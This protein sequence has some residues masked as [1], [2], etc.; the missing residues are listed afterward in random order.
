MFLMSS[1]TPA[2]VMTLSV[3]LLSVACGGD[4]GPIPPSPVPPGGVTTANVYILPGAADLGRNAFG[5][6]PVVIYKGEEMRWRNVDT[7]EHNVVADTASLT[8][9]GT[10]GALAPGGERSFLMKTTGTTTIHCTIHPQIVGTLIVQE[11]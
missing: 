4:A 1:P 10:T 2:R 9:F 3:L 5:D 6:H 8:E 11:P 7:T